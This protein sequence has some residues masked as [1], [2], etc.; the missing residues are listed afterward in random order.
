VCDA[1]AVDQ[2]TN[3]GKIKKMSKTKTTIPEGKKKKLFN[4]L[5]EANVDF[6]KIYPGDKPDRQA[7]HTVYGG[8]NLFKSNSAKLLGERALETFTEY[9]P[10]FVSFGKIFGL[11][12]AAQ[13]NGTLNDVKRH[14]LSL[15]P[16]EQKNILLVCLM[17][18]IIR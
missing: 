9:A 7:V 5:K 6:Q 17:K 3:A 2:C 4:K 8:A 16:E 10:D 1:T 14:Y 12:G 18:Y 11:D 13:I 15:L